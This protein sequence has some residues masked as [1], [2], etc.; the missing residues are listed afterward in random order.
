MTDKLHKLA[1]SKI[2]PGEVVEEGLVVGEAARDSLL[3]GPPA[4]PRQPI[5]ANFEDIDGEDDANALQEACRNLR[6]YAW[7]P[8]DLLF[9][10]GQIEIKM[11]SVGVKK[12]FTKFQVLS[13]IIPKHVT[14]EVKPLLRM[15]E[16]EFANND[17]YKQLKTEILRIFGAR[18]EKAVE[19]ALARVMVGP[20]SQLLRALHEDITGGKGDCANCYAVISALW[21]RHLSSQVRAGIAEYELTKENFKELA[22]RADDIHFS[23]RPAAAISAVTAESSVPSSPAALNETQP[24][25]SY[26]VPEVNA[27]RNQ[28]GGGRGGRGYR[29]GRGGRGNRGGSGGGGNSGGTSSGAPSSGTKHKGTKHPDLPAGDWSGC[30]MHFKFGRSAYFCAEPATCPWKNVFTQRPA[31]Q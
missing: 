17:S 16:T 5:M 27:V 28:R 4:Q 7:S 18:P 1:C 6:N 13:T 26:P 29:G 19:R 15:Q 10:F 12:Q 14:D 9:Y 2:V 25:L 8:E 22:K 20:P 11:S 31:K 24:G 21:R 3:A 30:G 23:N